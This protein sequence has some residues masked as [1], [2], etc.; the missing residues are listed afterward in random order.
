MFN[1]LFFPAL[2]MRLLHAHLWITLSRMKT[3]NSNHSIVDKSLNFEQVDRE[4]N[5]D[6][7][8]NLIAIVAYVSPPRWPRGVPL[9][10]VHRALHHHYLYSR[11]DYHRHASVVT[12]PIT[13]V[14]HP[15]AEELVYFLLF[16]IPP[17]P[18]ALTGSGSIITTYGYLN[19]I[20]FM[21]YMCHCNFE[22]VPKWLLDSL[23]PLKYLIDTPSF[24]SLHHTR[25][26]T[27]YSLFMPIYDYIRYGGR[28]FGRVTR[29]IS[30]EK[31]G[32][33]RCG[34]SDPFDHPAVHVSLSNRPF[35][36]GIKTIRALVVLV[37]LLALHA[38]TGA[39]GMAHRDYIHRGEE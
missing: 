25:F 36:P 6:D 33:G 31:G 37:D 12:E 24:H 5:W 16:A 19:Y 38:L 29:K 27:N 28:V 39:A 14:I 3:A 23:P 35:F 10:L 2:L 22:M 20:D 26:R 1:F 18:A 11:Y 9:L 13:T 30:Q 34:S 32:D 7:Q 21:N 15:F 8:I 4:R 17:I